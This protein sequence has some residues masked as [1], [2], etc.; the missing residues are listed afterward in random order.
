MLRTNRDQLIKTAVM[1]AITSSSA[2][3]LPNRA[4]TTREP[5]VLPSVG[6]ITYNL[7]VGDLAAGWQADHVEPGV[8]LAVIQRDETH[9]S[10]EDGL[11]LL[12]CVGNEAVVA[13][14]EASGEKGRVTGKHGGI[15]HVL[16]D[17]PEEVKEAL[18]I[19]T[20][21]LI[22][23]YGV[24]LRLLDF[25]DVTVT[26]MDPDL[27]EAIP[28]ELIG[29]KLGFPVTH[30]IPTELMGPCVPQAVYSGDYD[31]RLPGKA[32]VDAY[33]LDDLRLGDLVAIVSPNSGRAQGFTKEASTIGVIVHSDSV[34]VG[35]GPGVTALMASNR[36]RII[37][38]VEPHA[39]IVEYLGIR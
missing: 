2:R 27:L 16:V 4:S 18:L 30:L 6:G 10:I 26:N 19:G 8:S 14:G 23:A 34:V 29:D 31:I 11:C 1:G 5:L 22:K 13:S 25:G 15:N 21:V 37:P 24:G 7:R 35:H 28:A 9:K 32:L 20:L 17:F 3:K 33:H 12:S 38:R 39:N 36:A